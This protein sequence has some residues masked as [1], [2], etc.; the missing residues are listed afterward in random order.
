L[1]QLQVMGRE[2]S[3]HVG[4]KKI[5]CSQVC[6]NEIEPKDA[7]GEESSAISHSVHIA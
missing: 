5:G 4:R 6:G 1:A 7:I 3:R 2:N